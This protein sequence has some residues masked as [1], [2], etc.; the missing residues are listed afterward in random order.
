MFFI[1]FTIFLFSAYF[2]VSHKDDVLD[3]VDKLR[4]IE[5]GFVYA[6]IKLEDV[7]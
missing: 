5:K 7:I 3:M 4:K 2:R 1:L 6:D